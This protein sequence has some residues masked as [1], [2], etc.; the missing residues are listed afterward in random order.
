[1]HVGNEIMTDECSEHSDAGDLESISGEST[2]SMVASNLEDWRYHSDESNESDS[3][4]DG[5]NLAWGVLDDIDLFMGL[6][7]E[8]E[9]WNICMSH[10]LFAPFCNSHRYR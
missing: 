10:Q 1:M 4:V 8:E 3:E 9:T 5:L 2:S 6:E 7:N